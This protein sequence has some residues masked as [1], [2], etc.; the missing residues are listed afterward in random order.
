MDRNVGDADLALKC[1]EQIFVKAGVGDG[2]DHW[3]LFA[4]RRLRALRRLG[5]V[6]ADSKI[7]REALDAIIGHDARH[8]RLLEAV[9]A[10]DRLI[11]EN[12]RDPYWRITREQIF[13]GLDSSQ[14]RLLRDKLK[15]EM[16]LDHP[17]PAVRDLWSRFSAEWKAGQGNLPPVIQPLP[18]GSPLS[19]MEP[20]DPD[21]EWG[22]VGNRSAR[23][24]SV[25]L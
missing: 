8:G 5:V 17:D 9:D 21:G 18:Q 25:E 1:L 15:A 11:S 22:V 7:I 10:V 12:P 3:K 4:A 14:T 19:L 6:S 24:S 2:E 13:R 20:D 16:D 23:D